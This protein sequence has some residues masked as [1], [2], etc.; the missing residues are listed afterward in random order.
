M[1]LPPRTNFLSN[2]M[3]TYKP[4]NSTLDSLVADLLELSSSLSALR[5]VRDETLQTKRQ[6]R[7]Q[8]PEKVAEQCKTPATELLATVLG[9]MDLLSRRLHTITLQ[10]KE[11]QAQAQNLM[12]PNNKQVIDN[13]PNHP[14]MDSRSETS[15][16]RH[17]NIQLG[18]SEQE[19]ASESQASETSSS[20]PAQTSDDQQPVESED[21]TMTGS[22]LAATNSPPDSP[23]DGGDDINVHRAVYPL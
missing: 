18:I 20:Q 23:K 6:T 4:L 10:A 3:S 11:A 5:S 17:I 7:S 1:S 22:D 16:E 13:I 9:G 2:T 14:Q 15:C 19:V 8:P 12:V 21:V